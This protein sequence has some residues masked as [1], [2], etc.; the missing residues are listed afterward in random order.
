MLNKRKIDKLTKP[1]MYRDEKTLYL[2]VSVGRDGQVWKSWIQRIVCPDGKRRDIGLGPWPLI[3][4]EAARH[5]A[6]ENR[7]AVHH[8]EDPTVAKRAAKRRKKEQRRDEAARKASITFREAADKCLLA[9]RA[10]WKNSKTEAAWH[11]SLSDWVFPKIGHLPVNE[12]DRQMVLAIFAP[13]WTERHEIARK[14]RQRVRTI[15]G[16]A[17]AHN[18]C[19]HNPADDSISAALP[20]VRRGS[21]HHKA[22]DYRQV[23]AALETITNTNASL[24]AKLALRFQVLTAARP[25]E[26]R[27][28]QWSEIDLEANTWIIPAERMK[29]DQAHR[30]PLSDQA[31]AVLREAATLGDSGPCFPSPMKPGKPLSDMAVGKLLRENGVQSVPHGFRSSFRDWCAETGK[32]RELAEAALS[33]VVGGVEAAYF[34]SDVFER[35]R[36]LME[37]WGQ[38]ATGTAGKV[39]KL[40]RA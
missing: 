29:T 18:L 4:I 22:L 24:A 38:F 9:N 11:R 13:I 40:K 33:H 15:F 16:W 36:D 10:R 39:V 27:E 14:T 17:Q 34:R 35:R 3:T 37:A 30:V 8:G 28:A 20:K 7:L 25:T 12:I 5:A 19:T 32:P 2:R 31:I 23:P 21:K 26:G 6:I 1:G